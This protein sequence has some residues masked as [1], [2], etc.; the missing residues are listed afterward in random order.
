MLDNNLLGTQASFLKL[1]MQNNVASYL[2]KPMVENPMAMWQKFVL[3]S[4]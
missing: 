3:I 2:K 1:L 4:H